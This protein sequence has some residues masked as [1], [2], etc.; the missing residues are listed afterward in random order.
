MPSAG[1]SFLM[2]ASSAANRVGFDTGSAVGSSSATFVTTASRLPD[3]F[4]RLLTSMPPMMAKPRTT[5]RGDPGTRGTSRS[6]NSR[7]PMNENPSSC[8]SNPSGT[9]MVMPPQKAKAVISI[10]GPSSSARRKSR[11]QPPIT[12]TAFVFPLMRHRPLVLWPLMTATCQRPFLLGAGPPAASGSGR[13]AGATSGRSAMTA[14]RSPRVRAWRADPTR[15]ENSSRVRR[16]STRWSLS[17]VTARSRSASA[18]SSVG[19]PGCRGSGGGPWGAGGSAMGHSLPRFAWSG[20]DLTTRQA[21]MRRQL[22]S[23]TVR[24]IL[25]AAGYVPYRRLARA[26]IKDFMG[27][28]GGKGTRA[29]ASHD[30]DSTT[31]GVEAARLALRSAPGHSPETLF[32]ATSEPAYLDKTNATAIAA[33]VR[34]PG[35]IG[36][37]DFGG[38]L[39]SGTGCLIAALRGGGTT[40]VVAG[41]LRDGLPTSADESSGGD[42]GAAVLVGEGPGLLAEFVASASASDEFTDRWRAPGD[43]TSKLWEE[44]FGENRYLALGQDALARAIKAAGL[45]TEDIGRLVVTGMHGRAVSGLVKKLGLGDSV[46]V[47]DLAQSVG[48]SGTA[49]PLL[50]LASALESMAASGVPAGTAVAAVHLADGADAVVLRTTEALTRWEPARP[51]ATQVAAGAPLPYAKFLAW[52]GQLQPEPPRRPEPARVSSTAAHRNEDWKFGF[53]GSKDRSSGAVHLPPSRVSMEGGAV[54]DMEPV[55]MADATGTVITSTIDRLAYSPSPPIVFAV[56][57]FDG[58]GRYP[59]ELTDTDPDEIRA[60]SRV[61]MTFRRLFSADGIHDYFWKARPVRDE[62]AG[63]GGES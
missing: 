30:E 20:R 49:H 1:R 45:Q 46:L 63:A 2:S 21:S 47:D 44:R 24:G 15:S 42:A 52:R 3:R 10:S 55:A 36:A 23:A 14:T 51:V 17:W 5:I 6:F 28:G 57:D 33:A 12:A 43:R 29:V 48:Q 25:S 53:I 54:D 19:T 34:L 38:A 61:E 27:S 7:P 62:A 37:Y 35:D 58:G 22:G 8:T 56:V 11:S 26:D 16:P 40:L 59:V 18:T 9:T 50:V 41:D 31:L 13:V 4:G 39:R 32:F 60:G